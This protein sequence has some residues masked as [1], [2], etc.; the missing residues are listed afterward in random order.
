M[1][2]LI[3]TRGSKNE[4]ASSAGNATVLGRARATTA[5]AHPIL[6]SRPIT[7]RKTRAP[8]W[9]TKSASPRPSSRR[10]SRRGGTARGRASGPSGCTEGSFY[11]ARVLLDL[12]VPPPA[13]PA[14][15][16]GL[17]MAHPPMNPVAPGSS[18]WRLVD[19]RRSHVGSLA[20]SARPWSTSPARSREGDGKHRQ[21]DRGRT[22]LLIIAPSVRAGRRCRGGRAAET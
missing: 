1:P 19:S 5:G 18:V 8:P 11:P 12:A 17:P 9:S 7:L 2:G 3:V 14:L 6:A 4:G 15:A 16:E 10:P 22:P 20:P 21:A 13:N